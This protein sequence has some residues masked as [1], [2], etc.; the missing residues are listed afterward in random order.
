MNA[1]DAIKIFEHIEKLNNPALTIAFVLAV[2]FGLFFLARKFITNEYVTAGK[3]A[4]D[5]Q[6]KVYQELKRNYET[7]RIECEKMTDMISEYV[8]KIEHLENEIQ[9]LKKD[10]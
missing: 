3:E 8:K 6:R 1:S 5:E 4:F 10:G 9:S 7:L 2:A